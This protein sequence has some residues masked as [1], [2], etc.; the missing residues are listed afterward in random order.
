MVN[1]AGLTGP[2]LQEFLEDQTKKLQELQILHVKKNVTGLQLNAV[3]LDAMLG[4]FNSWISKD[5]VALAILKRAAQSE[6]NP[7]GLNQN[8]LNNFAMKLARMGIHQ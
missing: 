8:D 1:E 6:T 7:N 5:Q 3:E 2:E 4:E